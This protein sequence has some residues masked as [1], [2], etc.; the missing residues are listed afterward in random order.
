M[1]AI[2]AGGGIGGLTAALRLR[3][4]GL[5]V[6]VC[7]SV[8]EIRALGVGINL[9]PHAVRELAG[10]GRRE[11]RVAAM[12]GSTD[13]EVLLGSGSVAEVH[14]AGVALEGLAPRWREARQSG[15]PRVVEWSEGS[16]VAAIQAAALGL[17]SMPWPAGLGTDLPRVNPWLK[18]ATDPHTGAPVL[19]VRA[20]VPDVA[21][22]HVSAV[23]AD[24]NAYV[25]GDL[26]A[27]ALLARAARRVIVTY[28][29]L[30]EADAALAA[31]SR[32]WIDELVEAPG[33]ARPTGCPPDYEV[34]SEGLKQL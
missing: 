25:D 12:L 17:D 29:R 19:A 4:A 18:E 33:G 32:I 34:D 5:E 15:S 24:G 2:I 23:D 28:E 8:R 10:L 14:S 20:L 13:V 11:L 30:I 16:F 31:I 27:D 22:I 7:E 1:R 9:L 21:L 26:V 6:V 3:A